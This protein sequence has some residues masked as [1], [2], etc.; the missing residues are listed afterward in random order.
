M[1][2]Y[3]SACVLLTCCSRMQEST[4]PSSSSSKS[5]L[6]VSSVAT[7]A[8][9]D[10][11]GELV[12]SPWLP[13]QR[14]RK[15]GEELVCGSISDKLTERQKDRH[16]TLAEAGSVWSEGGRV[17][18]GAR[19]VQHKFHVKAGVSVCL[20]PHLPVDSDIDTNAGA[21]EA[22]ANH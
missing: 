6:V 5:V 14:R 12:L 16:S 21:D 10:Q 17:Q 9:R 20:E 8:K 18:E 1:P 3:C 15:E 11:Y 2:L 19:A 7:L 22:D 4:P 13:V